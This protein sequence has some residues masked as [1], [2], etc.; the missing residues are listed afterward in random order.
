M[1]LEA[2]IFENL[3]VEKK[4]EKM[5]KL[6]FIAAIAFSMVYTVR[7]Q[8]EIKG[9]VGINFASLANPPSGSDWQAQAGYQFGGG[10]L[11]GEKF[12]V[13]PGIQFVRNSRVVT[14]VNVEEEFDF[15][16]NL[17]K[18]P[19]YAGYHLLGHE[20]G[21]LALRLFAGPAVSVA[22]KIKKGE[23]QITKDDIKNAHFMV[24][25][26]VGLDILFLFVEFN[27]E[28]AFTPYFTDEA[29]DSNHSGFLIN[30]GIHIDF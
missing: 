4:N 13:E 1:R 7:G 14:P 21:P 26:G 8:F 11:I 6:V 3:Y 9:L 10:V 12:Y 18:I 5:K 23:D 29:F 24:D 15:S 20:S 22:G 25:A 28:Y 30:A 2:L 19:V 16:Q 17:V 27:Y